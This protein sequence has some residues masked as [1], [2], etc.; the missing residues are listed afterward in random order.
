MCEYTGD[1][2]GKPGG[3]N[4]VGFILPAG[5]LGRDKYSLDS[6]IK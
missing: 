3:K 2:N 1:P 6:K 5:L 4:E